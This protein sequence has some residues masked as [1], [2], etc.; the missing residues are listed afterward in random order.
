MKKDW[1]KDI[2][3]RMADFEVDVPKG[4]DQREQPQGL[5][6][7][8]CSAETKT[9]E[10]PAIDPHRRAWIG[11]AAAV[12]ACML[13]IWMI[14]PDLVQD[15]A[16]H[17]AQ[18]TTIDN[19]VITLE[20]T[21]S[22]VFVAKIIQEADSKKDESTQ[23]SLPSSR[24]DKES[25]KE[26]QKEPQK[27]S[28]EE[29][30]KA[31]QEKPQKEL[32][33]EPQRHYEYLAQTKRKRSHDP[34]LTVGLSTSGGVGYNDRQ[35]FMGGYQ[36][37]SSM[38]SESDWVDSPLLGIMALNRGVETEKKVT[39]HAPLRAGLSFSYR[40]NDRWSIESGVSYAFVSSDIH[41]GSPSNFIEEEQKLHYVG[42]PL[43]VTYRVFSWKRLDL[44]LSTNLLAEQRVSGQT[45]RKFIIGDKSQGEDEEK[46]ISSRPL[47][48][49]IGAKA[50]L[51]YNLNS[52]LSFYAEPGCSYYFDDRSSL[53]TVFKD[54]PFDF[55]MNVGLRFTV[56]K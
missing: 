27:A 51:Q 25:N 33:K 42:I 28:Q 9:A 46:S 49:S 45:T 12:A 23:A 4:S 8:I 29:P 34:R 22:R 17:F 13:L 2:H 31:S 36:G 48:M 24:S 50:G 18:E 26:P 3:D 16:T 43:G 32:P 56:G 7:D 20:D 11:V 52:L 40:L 30:Q 10:T 14:H 1:L 47:Q 15:S 41:E 35:Q 21:P 5:W 6:E 37:A 39:H 53:E 38:L 44:Y 19:K 55:N 54:K